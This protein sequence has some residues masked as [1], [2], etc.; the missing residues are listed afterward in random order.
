MIPKVTVLTSVFNGAPFLDA[1]IE[2]IHGQTF[3]DFEYLLVDDASTDET[4]AILAA[5]ASRDPRIIVIRN[6]CNMGLTRSLNKGI[7]MARGQWIA[8]QDADDISL[9]ERLERQ[10]GYLALQPTVGLLGTG[11]WLM[12]ER[13]MLDPQPRSGPLDH[14]MICWH[15][16]FFNPFFHSSVM[17]LRDLAYTYDETL[18]FGQDFELWG[19]LLTRTCG[20]NLVEP[21]VC[22]RRHA[23]RVSAVYYQQ[24]QEI[25]LGIVHQRCRGVLPDDAWSD[26]EM[27]MVRTMAVSAWPVQG[28]TLRATL[29]LLKIFQR[30]ERQGRFESQQLDRLRNQL[31]ERLWRSVL[32]FGSM[33]EKWILFGAMGRYLGGLGMLRS[34][35]GL[36]KRT[37]L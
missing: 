26:Q 5:W 32:G 14:A 12:D 11:A 22:L 2:S 30:F 9:P 3:V 21:L 36:M 1:A 33:R 35:K 8:R 15:L 10:V 23:S 29:L 17:F 24:Q 16:L 37:F 7:R 18:R 13:G 27:Q 31:M 34:L 19:R 20:A 6:A 28:E 4:P 25:A